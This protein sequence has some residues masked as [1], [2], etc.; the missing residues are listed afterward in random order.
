MALEDLPLRLE[1]EEVGK[2]VLDA[3]VVRAGRVADGREQD[4]GLAVPVGDLL[5]V[6]R[7]KRVVPQAEEAADLIVRDRLSHCD[8][9]RH[10]RGVVVL[11]LPDSVLLDIVERV[12]RLDLVA[13]RSHGELVDPGIDGPAVS[14][15][16]LPLE[17]RAL[18]LLEQER[19]EVVLH[20]VVVGAGHVGHGGQEAGLLDIPASDDAAVSR[21]EG[22]VPQLEEGS[23]LVLADGRPGR[24]GGGRRQGDLGHR[25]RGAGGHGPRPLVDDEVAQRLVQGRGAGDA[26][27][28][29][30]ESVAPGD[31]GKGDG[32]RRELHDSTWVVRK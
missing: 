13:G 3:R 24:R 5:R 12:A 32:D 16:D 18:R 26:G 25:R 14:G 11:D 27:V 30:D 31:K 2:V 7:G 4:S 1:L 8:L 29:G 9:L 22:L 20:R 23:D 15:V 6:E 28:G 10:D 17:D 19:V 21:G